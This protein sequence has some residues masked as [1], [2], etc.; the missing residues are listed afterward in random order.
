M[1][2]HALVVF[3]GLIWQALGGDIPHADTTTSPSKT[4]VLTSCLAI[5]QHLLLKI[6]QFVTMTGVPP[7]SYFHPLSQPPRPCSN[8]LCVDQFLSHTASASS[9]CESYTKSSASHATSL[10]KFDN[11]CSEDPFRISSAC[12]YLPS[13]TVAPWMSVHTDAKTGSPTITHASTSTQ[14]PQLRHPLFGRKALP[15]AGLSSLVSGLSS[16]GTATTAEETLFPTSDT[17]PD[18]SFPP[19]TI[20]TPPSTLAMKLYGPIDNRLNGDLVPR[21]GQGDTV[22][23][24]SARPIISNHSVPHHHMGN[25]V[26]TSTVKLTAFTPTFTPIS[27]PTPTPDIAWCDWR[28]NTAGTASSIEETFGHVYNQTYR[29]SNHPYP[30]RVSLIYMVTNFKPAS[31]NEIATLFDKCVSYVYHEIA[32]AH[33]GA[34]ITPPGGETFHPEY[35][36]AITLNI[37]VRDDWYFDCYNDIFENSGGAGLKFRRCE[38]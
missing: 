22:I 3:I 6:L 15:P 14:T 7:A 33:S 24:V 4:T 20:Q 1:K 37:N 5:N 30:D 27:T 9:F 21:D 12:R 25:T 16:V 17:E 28:N 2:L 35:L 31:D 23:S 26:P 29:D 36:Y 32:R 10:P 13:V 34:L 11:Q 8:D 38:A 18:T 19:A